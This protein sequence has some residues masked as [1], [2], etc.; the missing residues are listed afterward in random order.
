MAGSRFATDDKWICGTATMTI[1]NVPGRLPPQSLDAERAVLAA[2]LL[3]RDA[4]AISIEHLSAD[5]FYR[6]SHREIY[7]AILSLYERNEPTDIVSLRN[8][9]E[10]RTELEKVG[11]AS[12][13]SDLFEYT[14]TAAN[15][16]HHCRIVRERSVLR[17]LIRV[18][19]DI[20]SDA[21]DPTSEVDSLLDRAEQRIFSIAEERARRGFHEVGAFIKPTME[22]F[23]DLYETRRH[24]TG[25]E[26]GFPDLD[27]LTAGWQRAD[28]IVIAGRPSMGK[29]ALLLNFAAHVGLELKQPVAVF[30]LEMSCQ[31]LTQRVLCSEAEVNLHHA[32][33]G[34]LREEE[35]PRLTHAASRLTNA[36][37]FIDDTPGLTVMEM[38]AKARRLKAEAGL[39]VI[40]VDYLQLA[41]GE[42]AAEN[43]QQE[44]ASVSR[45]LK[46]LA[47]ELNVPVIAGSQLSR[48]VEARTD[49]RPLLSDLRESG[50]IEQ[51]AD[52][53]C[54]IHRPEVYPQNQNKAE[55]KNYAELIIGKHRNGPTDTIHLTFIKEYARFRTWAPSYDQEPQELPT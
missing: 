20:A 34:K 8:E 33:T 46:A 17:S 18:A 13:L 27:R 11:G 3:D 10:R 38:R 4:I 36:K 6:E 54:F 7:R 5:D 19:T 48:A 52:V 39:Q 29:T 21:F 41:Q 15:I 23:T 30:S 26:S 1:E 31:Q 2:M 22:T 40:I 16:V 43:R 28:F 24:I 25:I 32:R 42:A 50:A 51:D 35:W 12:Y 37:I 55:L 53:V 14:V 9:L 45:G 44:I 47:K 49:R